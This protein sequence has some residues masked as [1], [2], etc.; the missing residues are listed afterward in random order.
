MAVVIVWCNPSKQVFE[1]GRTIVQI[2]LKASLITKQR[3]IDLH[4]AF[5]FF[6]IKWQDGDHQI[7]VDETNKITAM[8]PQT[9][10]KATQAF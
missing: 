5:I 8:S 10:K 1:K 3:S 6:G 9:S 7:P 4:K 2:F